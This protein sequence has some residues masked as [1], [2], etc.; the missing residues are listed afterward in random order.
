MYG[1]VA[2]VRP[3]LSVQPVGHFYCT[4]SDNNGTLLALASDMYSEAF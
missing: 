2:L 1:L 4:M 3:G